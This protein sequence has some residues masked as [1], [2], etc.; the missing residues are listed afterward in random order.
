MPTTF[1]VILLPW[2][3]IV[4]ILAVKNEKFEAPYCAVSSGLRVNTYKYP[5]SRLFWNTYPQLYSFLNGKEHKKMAAMSLALLGWTSELPSACTPLLC[6]LL[7]VIIFNIGWQ[8]PK[9]QDSSN[10]AFAKSWRENVKY[11]KNHLQW[12]AL[13]AKPLSHL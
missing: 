10:P 4:S 5:L 3:P 13:A 2:L 7:S 8:W 11:F 12:F 6:T 1:S 9:S